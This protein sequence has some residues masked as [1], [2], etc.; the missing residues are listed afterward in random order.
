MARLASTSTTTKP[1]VTVEVET[2]DKIKINLVRED[3]IET[4]NIYRTFFEIFLLIFGAILGGIISL[5]NEN[6]KIPGLNWFFLVLMAI[7]AVS[8]YILSTRIH[9]KARIPISK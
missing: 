8:F 9:K 7:L 1:P 6:K 5:L 2:P 4:S 3:Y